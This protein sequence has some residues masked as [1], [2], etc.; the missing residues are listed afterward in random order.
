[1]F[2]VPKSCLLPHMTQQSVIQSSEG[3]KTFVRS[4]IAASQNRG[5]SHLSAEGARKSVPLRGSRPYKS[6]QTSINELSVLRSG[7]CGYNLVVQ[8]FSEAF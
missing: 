5:V 3:F 7:L 8:T 1:M 6:F 2:S 4:K